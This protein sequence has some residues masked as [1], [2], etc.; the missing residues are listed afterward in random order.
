MAGGIIISITGVCRTAARSR[1]L[2]FS[3]HH[4]PTSHSVSGHDETRIPCQG[5]LLVLANKDYR[6]QRLTQLGQ[7]GTRGMTTRQAA[8]PQNADI[9]CVHLGF[10][11]QQWW[12]G[13]GFQ[14]KGKGGFTSLQHFGSAPSTGI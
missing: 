7:N 1:K 11:I 10:V 4:R 6:N 8:Q 14:L 12:S 5:N 9:A 2:P 3:S 13:P